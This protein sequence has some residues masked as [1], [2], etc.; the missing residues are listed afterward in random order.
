[1]EAEKIPV[2]ILTGFL[3]SGKTTLLNHILTAEHGKKLAVI[4]NEFGETD[5]DT[6]VLEA[7]EHSN[8]TIIEVKNGCICCTVR[9]D[10]VES[11]AKIYKKTKGRLDGVIIETTGLADPAPVCQTFFV[12]EKISPYF[13]IDAVITVVDCKHLLQHLQEEKA[14]GVENESVE[15]LAFA[16]K[17]LLNKVDL[18]EGD[19]EGLANIEREIRNINA[20]AP[21]TRTM[22][23]DEAPP[24][25]E[26][27]GLDAFSL[28]RVQELDAEFLTEDPS[29]HEHDNTVT[30]M[31]FTLGEDEQLNVN[32]LEEWIRHLLVNYNETLFRYKGVI[33]VRGMDKKFIFQG[34]HMLFNG[35]FAGD[36]GDQTRTSCFCFIGRNLPEMNL[37][38]GFRNCVA[39]PLRFNIGDNVQCNVAQGYTNGRVM[40]QWDEGNAYRVR[41]VTGD[42][43]WA[44]IDVDNYIRA[45]RR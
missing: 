40:K 7:K 2:T 10:L 4:E 25:S 26:L 15:Q 13:N 18:F 31:G 42:E 45:A 33:A 43:V 30:S 27:L 29:S 3:G 12:E 22:L 21:I 19:E 23:K 32:K 20:Y 5:V 16:D 44:P 39:A 9:G 24:M 41:L 11:L 28:D 36:W 6:A 17:V 1:M 8:E 38:A 37:E 14:D 34:V 35:S